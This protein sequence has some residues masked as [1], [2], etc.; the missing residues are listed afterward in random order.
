MRIQARPGSLVE[1]AWYAN[2]SLPGQPWPMP[3]AIADGI[4]P[5]PLDDLVFHGGRVVPQMGFQ[6]I[7]LGSHTDWS[8]SDIALIDAAI[9][10]AMQDRRLNNVMSQ[11]FP[12]ARVSCDAKPSIV[13]TDKKPVQLDE[14]DVQAKIV[15]L[16]NA[17]TL[18]DQD[19][20]ATLFNL[21]LRP[22]LS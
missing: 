12:G 5:S 17:K 18:G 13:L 3:K 20:G 8:S 16:F 22:E 2:S 14:P 11:Y 7:Y 9:T 21:L 10:R 4:T 6:N 19:I 15:A 1:K